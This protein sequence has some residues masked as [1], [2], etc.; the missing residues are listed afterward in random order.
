MCL[1]LHDSNFVQHSSIQTLF[2]ADEVQPDDWKL[3]SHKQANKPV[4]VHVSVQGDTK[5]DRRPTHKARD[6]FQPKKQEQ[7]YF[8]KP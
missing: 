6:S 8:R 5:T 7:R 3:E 4:I 2:L 1:I